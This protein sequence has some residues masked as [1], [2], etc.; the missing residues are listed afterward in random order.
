MSIP[1][2][3]GGIKVTFLILK[4]IRSLCSL[5]SSTVIF[6]FPMYSVEHVKSDFNEE[7][8]NSF[9]CYSHFVCCYG[10]IFF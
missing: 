8:L 7:L 6:N 5:N 3:K 10:I 4:H 9:K 2:F 1:F